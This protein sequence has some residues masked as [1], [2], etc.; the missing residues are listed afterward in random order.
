MQM[1]SFRNSSRILRGL[2]AGLLWIGLSVSAFG[3]SQYFPT[4][5]P[6]PLG[7][8]WVVA[9]GQI[10]T[11]AGTQVNLVATESSGTGV[12][13]KAIA[14]NPNPLANG[15]RT[16]AVLTLGSKSVTG[17]VEVFDVATGAILQEFVPNSHANGSTAGLAYTKDGS[18]LLFSQDNSYVTVASVG[19]DGLLTYVIQVNLPVNLNFI[20]CFPNSPPGTTGS[21][22]IPC[23]QTVSS[24][25]AYPLGLAISADGKTAYSVLDTDDSL[26][27]IDLTTSPPTQLAEIRVGNV[28]NSVVLSSDGGTAYVSN[29]AGRVATVNDFQEYSNGTPVVATNP[30]GAIATATISVVNLGSFSVT[31]TITLTGLHPTGMALWGQ[32]L[33]VA[34]TYSDVISVIDTTTNTEVRKIKLGLP[35]GVLGRTAVPPS[36]GSGPS[37]YGAAPNSIAVDAVNN[38]AYV[39][40]YNANAVAVVDLSDGAPKP[41][42]G[43]IP[44]GY[45]P[46]SVVLDTP[47]SL[48][49][50][51]NDKGIGTT[52]TNL[53]SNCATY[54]GVC[55]FNSHQDQGTVSIVPIPGSAMLAQMSV[56]VFQNNHWDLA[57]NISGAWG[58]KPSNPPV[59]I[60]KKIGDPS[61]I[62]HVFVI[63]RENRTYD[64]ILGDVPAGNGD[65]TLAVFGGIYTPNAH[66]LV[67]RFPLLD[68][69]YDPSRQSADGHNWITQAMAPYSDDIQSPDWVRDYPSNGG[70][71]LAYQNLGHLW[72][73]AV[74]ANVSFKNYGE[75]VEFNLFSP[76]G[77]GNQEPSWC[78][79]YDDTQSYE[80]G[81]EQQLY[82]YNTV[83]S[84][85]PLPNLL[86]HTVQNYPQFDLGI[87]DQFRFDIWMQDF[88]ND[89]TNGTVPQLE[90]MWISS[91][92]TGGPPNAMAMQADNDLAMGR[93]VDA[94][95]HS[96]IWPTSAIFIEEDDAQNGVDHVDGHRSPGYVVSPYVNQN[97][98]TD[99]TFYTQVNMTRTIEQ[100]LGI[101]PMNQFDLWASPM[102]TI[103]TDNPPQE[104]FQ[105]WT[106]TPAEYPLTSGTTCTSV[107]AKKAERKDSPKVAALRAAWLQKKAQIFAGNFTKP[108]VEDPDTVRHYNWYEATGFT[109]P[110]PGEKTVRQ[111]SEFNNSAPITVDKD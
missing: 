104:N 39:A 87:P 102:R 58:G 1:N 82:Y 40:L 66:L 107:A 105:P 63:I 88:Q 23:G 26:T 92:H 106:H 55:G 7:N 37:A 98:P 65:P 53:S 100:I 91:D 64:Q 57:A 72:D 60:P 41:I 32:Y 109:R 6:G 93:Y 24:N 86:S 95:T 59:A 97:G 34:D 2:I 49:L 84:Y 69:F 80:N 74:K 50:V 43:M 25:T 45:A 38:I 44:V 14:L 31:A 111:P 9:N 8:G 48:L 47:D 27:K 5:T 22:P 15:H 99:H 56:Q 35:I 52:N 19:P 85:T 11:P 70:D 10:I 101:T 28:P 21:A 3:Q 96:S 89:V 4:Y 16:A 51:A 67:Q 46:S 17:A 61:F 18:H 33:L 75:Y 110:Y 20:T 71:S 36:P 73:Q 30:T 94:I 12:R 68:N 83:S 79:F 54:Y 77:G 76:P 78:Q 62:K 90:F 13:A 103:F 42:K 81:Q 29:E 108:D